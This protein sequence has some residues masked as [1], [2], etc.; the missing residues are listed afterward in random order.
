MTVDLIDNQEPI[1][2]HNKLG[3][4]NLEKRLELLEAKVNSALI[5][6][7]PSQ[8]YKNQRTIYLKKKV[9]QKI[10]QRYRQNSDEKLGKIV[11]RFIEW[12]LENLAADPPQNNLQVKKATS[13]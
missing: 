12:C 10:D 2:T 6:R 8:T 13:R 4:K 9:A 11:E 3:K 1:I 7:Q 5:R